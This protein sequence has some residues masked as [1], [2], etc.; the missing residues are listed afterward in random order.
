MIQVT[1]CWLISAFGSFNEVS[2][3]E[4]TTTWVL[5]IIQEALWSNSED[6]GGPSSALHESGNLVN[7]RHRSFDPLS[8]YD[9]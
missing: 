3:R 9:M 8:K 4:G 6:D 7:N 5:F 2:C 1:Q